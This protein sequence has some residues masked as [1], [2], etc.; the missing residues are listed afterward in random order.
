MKIR[1]TRRRVLTAT[2]GLVLGGG[3]AIH[4]QQQ[5]RLAG[6]PA[7]RVPPVNELIN[8]LEME[9]MARR[10]LDSVT[11]AGIADGGD[12]AAF[13][14][15]T[16]R[17]RLMVDTLQLDL[18]ID[19]FG[20]RMFAPILAGP[21]SGQQRF[22]PDAELATARGTAAAKTAMIVSERSTQP[23][24]RIA[25]EASGMPLWYQVFPDDDVDALRARID[26]AALGGCK[27]IFL[28]L[29]A[30]PRKP[31][32]DWPALDRLRK[33]LTMPF[34][35]K[36]IMSPTEARLAVEHGIQGIVV[37]SYRDLRATTP[38]A[39]PIEMLP[40][41]AEAVAGRIPILIDGGFRRGSDILK[42]LALGARAVLV[43]RPVLWGLA[44]YGAP[45]VQQV[46][47]LLQSEL[48]RDMAM[49][50]R[51]NLGAIDKT[52]VRLHRR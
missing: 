38:L 28:T 3:A 39:S 30:D 36:G 18:S 42:A 48:A 20:Q 31:A 12:R 43:S 5:P 40:S 41:I 13:D 37:S 35:L 23:L 29:G 34:L 15:I 8:T 16:F 44:A 2:T 33:G 27:V 11:F 19:L 22:H 50:G 24:A 47:E 32:M 45:G 25:A 14:R 26:Q 6:E 52:V 17:P 51:P 7:G 21:A 49:C 4:G 46:L 10:K 9:A 1:L